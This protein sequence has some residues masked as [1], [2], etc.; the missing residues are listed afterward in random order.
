MKKRSVLFVF[1]MAATACAPSQ[2][3]ASPTVS[4]T[5][6]PAPPTATLPPTSTATSTPDV[7]ATQQ[8]NDLFLWVEKFVEAGI[9]PDTSGQYFALD[10][11]SDSFAKAKYYHVTPLK[12]KAA[13]FILQARVKM[14]SASKDASKAGC[15]FVFLASGFDS[16]AIFFAQ[17]GNVNFL[18]NGY[19]IKSNY[20]DAGLSSNPD[21]NLITLIVY[22]KDARFFVN[23]RLGILLPHVNGVYR[24]GYTL[25]PEITEIGV[26]GPSVLSGTNEGFGTRCDFSDFH[27]WL[28]H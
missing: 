19:P 28:I 6:T 23:D 2:P 4:P 9:L 7:A 13:D 22:D 8:Y 1:L 11:V 10:D 12:M 14:Q 5:Y 18:A 16:R 26:F 15:G 25:T 21:G 3:A 24:I 17:D 20:L 27:L